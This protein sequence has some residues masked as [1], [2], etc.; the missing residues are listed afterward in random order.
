MI[1]TGNMLLFEAGTSDP[2]MQSVSWD[3]FDKI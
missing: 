2:E 1:I 3:S